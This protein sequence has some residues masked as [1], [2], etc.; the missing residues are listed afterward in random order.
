MKRWLT[1]LG[2]V[3]LVAAGGWFWVSPIM[4]MHALAVSARAGDR[5]ALAQE[6]DFPAVR[7]SLK[8]QLKAAMVGKAAADK[9]GSGAL[10]AL[11]MMFVAAIADSAIDAVVSPDG[12]KT[13]VDAGKVQKP[14]AGPDDAQREHPQW[15]I[16]RKGLDRFTARPVTRDDGKPPVLVFRRE[17]LSWR[18]ADIMLPLD[19]ANG[20]TSENR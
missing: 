9:D 14:G 13:L 3:L 18:L 17:G 15:V 4:A 2:V 12:I 10:A 6:V 11:G 19:E 8:D 20:P 5:D 16:A 1:G 7:Q